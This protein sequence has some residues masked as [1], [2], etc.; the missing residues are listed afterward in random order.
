MACAV[1]SLPLCPRAEVLDGTAEDVPL[2]DA[3][4]D[5]VFISE[6]FHSF[7]GE[8]ALAEIA[9]VLRPQG[10]LILLWNLPA[11]PTTP[12]IARVEQFLDE[13]GPDRVDLSYDPKDLN[14]R[15]FET[16][17]WRAPFIEGPYEEIRE[18]RLANPQTVTPDELVAFFGSM[19]WIADLPD[20]ERLPLLDELRSHLTAHEY[21]RS[22]ETRAYW[23]RLA[24]P[25]PSD[26]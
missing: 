5:A 7:D 18:V 13:R 10:V 16:D 3:S 24:A 8:R 2:D 12:S 6:A 21:T 1:C 26:V 19:G 9:R 25:N 11:G 4:I 17:E 23:T 20:R 15:R 22:W 14:P